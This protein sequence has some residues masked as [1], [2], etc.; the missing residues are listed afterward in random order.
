[1]PAMYWL[2]WLWLATLHV[3]EG[4]TDPEGEYLNWR[5][6]YK[7][8]PSCSEKTKSDYLDS[9]FRDMQKLVLDILN[10]TRGSRCI[11]T[12]VPRAE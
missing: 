1:M 7:F 6:L 2:L 9:A 10:S 4:D 8:S 11:L 3:V 12:A 5:E